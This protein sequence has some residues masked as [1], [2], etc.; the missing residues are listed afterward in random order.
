[1]NNFVTVILSEKAIELFECVFGGGVGKEKRIVCVCR[2]YA[3]QPKERKKY[4]RNGTCDRKFYRIDP[5]TSSSYHPMPDM[6][7]LMAFH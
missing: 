3:L 7:F 2:A 1:L 6:Q 4:G 5:V